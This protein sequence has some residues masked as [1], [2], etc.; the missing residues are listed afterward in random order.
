MTNNEQTTVAGLT[1][2]RICD[3]SRTCRNENGLLLKDVQFAR[4]IEAEVRADVERWA[5]SHAGAS[6]VPSAWMH[7]DGRVV[8][9]ATMAGARED[10]GAMLSSV[11]AYT[12]PLVRADAATPS[13]AAVRAAA[14][15]EAAKEVERFPHNREW[16]PGSLYGNLRVETAA[17]IRAL[18]NTP[19][20]DSGNRGES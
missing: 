14:L 2:A 5:A 6:A 3:I 4:A 10:G 15:E 1:D 7:E 16:V 18:I 13:T 8:T 9:A 20:A 19:A 17:D 12:I 11:R